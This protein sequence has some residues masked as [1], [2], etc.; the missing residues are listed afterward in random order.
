MYIVAQC[1]KT[2]THYLQENWRWWWEINMAHLHT[3]LWLVILCIMFIII[4]SLAAVHCAT[5]EDTDVTNHDCTRY[6][7]G[8]YTACDWCVITIFSLPNITAFD[9]NQLQWSSFISTV[10]I[11]EASCNKWY[12]YLFS[13]SHDLK[14]CNYINKENKK[15]ISSVSV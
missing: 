10:R 14:E 6:L 12:N 13:S 7:A 9:D 11:W 15:L 1:I 3:W 5:S 2:F 8:R 4:I